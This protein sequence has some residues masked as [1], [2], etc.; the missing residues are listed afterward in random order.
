[1]KS[2]KHLFPWFKNNPDIVYLDSGATTHKPQVVIDAINQYYLYDCTN[3]HNSDSTFAYKS[4]LVVENARKSLAK[5]INAKSIQEIVFTSGATESL[6]LI[7]NG[8]K[9]WLKK[10]DEIILTYSE[11]AS[12]LLPW[13]KLRE[14]I[15]IKIVFANQLNHYPTLEDFKNALSAKTKIVSFASGG[16]LVGNILDEVAI[17]K[18]V[19]EYNQ[20]ILVCV[21]ATQSIQHRPIDV[22]KTNCDFVVCSAH[23]IF[24]PTGIGL[25]YIKESLITKLEPLKYGGGMNFS[26]NLEKYELFDNLMR[27]EGGTPHVAG[28]YGFKACVDFLLDIGYEAIRNHELELVKYATE[29][30][31]TIEN[32]EIFNQDDSSTSIAFSYKNVFCQDFANYLGNKNIIVRSGLSC[33]KVINHIIGIE[34]AIRASF[35]LYNDKSD[36]DKLVKAIKEYKPGDELNGII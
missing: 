36:V 1:M 8:L 22:I 29:Q 18:I 4:H 2:Y 31:K 9:K 26:I 24:G 30:L 32:I 25:A 28:I 33:A 35:Y 11:H 27:F 13:Y 5:L 20:Q 21:D 3:P 19:K 14:E 34:C 23:K 15:G 17:T 16:N 12:N 10:D 7:A 6:N